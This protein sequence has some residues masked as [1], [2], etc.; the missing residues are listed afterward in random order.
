[1]KHNVTVLILPVLLSALVVSLGCKKRSEPE[2]YRVVGYDATAHEW[3]ILRNGTFNGKYLTKRL[4]VVCS[5]YKWGD[6]EAI[7]GPDACH[8]Q[9]G[10]MM[11]PNP[12]PPEGKRQEF[13]DIYEMP[14]E[15]LSITEG[16]GPDRVVQQFSILKY[17][18]LP[19]NTDRRYG[20]G[21]SFISWLS[22]PIVTLLIGFLLGLLGDDIKQRIQRHHQSCEARR[23]VYDDLGAYLGR[24]EALSLLG[25]LD[26]LLWNEVISPQ[27]PNF[28]YYSAHE[29]GV[30]LR[31]DTKRGVYK[32]AERLR[33]LGSAYRSVN[34]ILPTGQKDDS[35]PLT[36]FEDV[37]YRYREL[38]DSG[39]LDRRLL[40]KACNKQRQPIARDRPP[41]LS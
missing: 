38:L 20:G 19:D 41:L 10:R 34:P 13:L 23:R 4:T 8:L 17:E 33:A 37:L 25:G 30:L 5:S 21:M 3:T 39:F 32:L 22:N 18:V 31:A 2:G 28:D 40:A 1:M 15:T 11:I 6:H 29:P 16:D 36:F 24:V 14:G 7:T 35:L 9:V 26:L 12:L 27:A